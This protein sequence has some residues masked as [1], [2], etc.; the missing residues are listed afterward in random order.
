MIIP[1]K[2]DVEACISTI[3]AGT[4]DIRKQPPLIDLPP[5]LV[6]AIVDLVEY[7]ALQDWVGKIAVE[8][9]G[10][11]LALIG[12]HGYGGHPEK[13]S[14]IVPGLPNWRFNFHGI[15]CYF[16]NIDTGETI[17]VDF[18]GGNTETI[19]SFFFQVYLESL[20][21]PPLRWKWLARPRPFSESFESLISQLHQR[22]WATDNHNFKLSNFCFELHLTLSPLLDFMDERYKSG[23]VKSAALAVYSLNDGA[24]AG[25]LDPSNPHIVS[26]AENSIRARI[27]H[28]RN[29]KHEDHD[30]LELALL[31]RQVIDTEI[32]DLLKVGAKQPLLSCILEMIKEWKTNDYNHIILEIIKADIEHKPNVL[33]TAAHILLRHPTLDFITAFS[34]LLPFVEGH[35]AAEA[36]TY[37]YFIDRPRG[38]EMLNQCLRHQ[39]PGCRSHAAATLALLNSTIS[40]QILIS[41]LDQ[42]IGRIECCAAILSLNDPALQNK[43]QKY[44]RNLTKENAAEV[45]ERGGFDSDYNKYVYTIFDLQQLAEELREFLNN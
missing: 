19:K 17:D 14:G 13:Y 7:R 26:A 41:G 2:Q 36:A 32:R 3:K 18:I 30:L 25:K 45:L 35:D 6:W 10:A 38:L 42:K 9:L 5:N 16:E 39:I 43:V 44:Y 31:D 24:F 34:K 11:D 28:Y 15:G 40:R 33:I 37:L 22:G 1:S 21:H 29:S 8:R 23:D 27:N 20:A 12:G 4:Y